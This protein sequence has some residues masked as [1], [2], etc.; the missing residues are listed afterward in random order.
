MNLIL[1]DEI[2]LRD[3][4]RKVLSRMLRKDLD[5]FLSEAPVVLYSATLGMVESSA[6]PP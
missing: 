5:K 6:V 4:F 3:S 1:K 2:K